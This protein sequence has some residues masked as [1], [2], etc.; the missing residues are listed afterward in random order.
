MNR[1]IEQLFDAVSNGDLNG[2]KEALEK[3]ADVS[4]G[5]IGYLL[6]YASL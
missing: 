3:G 2:V 1:A 5:D 6:I 4:D